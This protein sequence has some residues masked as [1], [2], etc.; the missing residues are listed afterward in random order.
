MKISE[1]N[2][3]KINKIYFWNMYF[4]ISD[5]KNIFI[6]QGGNINR[7]KKNLKT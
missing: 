7:L 3:K 6:S 2:T 4:L 1:K 5:S